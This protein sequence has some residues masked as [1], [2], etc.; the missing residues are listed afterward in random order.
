L[1]DGA[2]LRAER[3]EP[4]PHGWRADIARDGELLGS[5]APPLA[6]RHNVANSLAVVGICLEL[7]VPFDDIAAALAEFPGVGRR[8]EV[9]GSRRGTVVVDDYAHHPTE[10][11][12]ALSAARQ[13]WPG[14]SVVAVF[15]PHLYSRT[16]MFADEFGSALS[17]AD[18]V[19]VLPI[20]PAREAPIAGVNAGMI[21]A[22][23]SRHGS[24]RVE[25]PA[26]DEA[27]LRILDEI[28]AEHGLVLTL[29]AGPVD[30]IGRAWLK[31][32]S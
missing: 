5:I 29:G 30:R 6:G 21:A 12:A 23:V 9:L 20:H 31:G 1:T 10:V 27:A 22:A 17:A 3:L 26:D 25:Q 2:W 4:S 14:R 19:V 11:R 24:A 18:L 32:G 8:L 7:G 15:E 16:R 28:V 13:A